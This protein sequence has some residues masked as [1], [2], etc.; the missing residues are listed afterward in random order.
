M[1]LAR[2]VRAAR[3]L[4]RRRGAEAGA[5]RLLVTLLP[6][7]RQR[8]FAVTLA[9]GVACGAVAVA[10]HLTIRLLGSL[11][12]DRAFAAPGPLQI[13]LVLL[14]PTLGGL[15]AGILL[16]YLVPEARGSGIPQVKEALAVAFALEGALLFPAAFSML[17]DREFELVL[18]DYTLPGT[19]GPKVLE[20]MRALRPELP[21]YFI[22]GR[23]GTESGLHFAIGFGPTGW[24]RKPFDLEEI[25]REIAR[26]VP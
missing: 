13:A 14:V 21:I 12:I 17:Q 20:A 18:L 6:A 10:F 11:L 19:S 5:L 23:T 4:G 9:A 24:I 1:G 22:S 3:R 7:E 8:V 26:S 15:A 25:Y 16:E 2:R